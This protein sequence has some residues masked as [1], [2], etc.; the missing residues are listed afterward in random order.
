MT[1]SVNAP[2]TP[3]TKGSTGISLATVPNVC[4]MPGPPAPFVP[5]PLPNIGKS[6]DSP[7]KYTKKVKVAGKTVAIKGASFKSMG[8]VASKGTGGGIV[9][10]NTHGATQFVGPGSMNVK[11][12]GKNVQLLGDP[13]TNNHGS[14]PNSATM[15]GVIQAPG[16]PIPPKPVDCD[17][18]KSRYP[19]E[20]YNDQKKKKGGVYDGTQSHHVIQNSHFQYPR[21]TTLPGICAGYD[22]GAAPCIPLDDGTDTSTAHGR[23][24]QMQKSDAKGYRHQYRDEGKSPTYADARKD[25]KKQLTAKNPGPGLSEE[26]AECIMIEVDKYFEKA[27]GGKKGSDFKLRPP[28]QRGKGLPKPPS[29]STLS[30]GSL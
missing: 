27:S 30:P 17:E 9:S 10:S 28:G 7:K 29:S 5:T 15:P 24:S 20:S 21:G 8:D 13:M 6:G 2:K 3:V 19:V 4:K 23:V 14:P 12:E 22:E 25:A 1:V 16:V 11:F 26:E 18:V